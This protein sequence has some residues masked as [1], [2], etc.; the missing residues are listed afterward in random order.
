V[1]IETLKN[2][3]ELAVYALGILKLGEWLFSAFKSWWRVR[4]LPAKD[5]LEHRVR[6]RDEIDKNL[7]SARRYIDRPATENQL[8]TRIEVIDFEDVIVRDMK[9]IVRDM[10]RM[11]EFPNVKKTSVGVSPWLRLYPIRFYDRGIEV[12]LSD[13]RSVIKTNRGW[14]LLPRNQHSESAVYAATVG[15][16]P[17]HFIER[18]DWSRNDGYYNSPHFYCRYV[19]PLRG[20]Y[21]DIVY[22]VKLYP[23]VSEHLSEIGLRNESYEWGILKR[24]AFLFRQDVIGWWQRLKKLAQKI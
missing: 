23:E 24:G 12:F 16:I 9:R 22:K 1:I 19:G 6:M 2:I 15:R 5:I 20:P 21:E 7:K 8:A 11:D 4:R 14:C 18:I 13:S 3:S 17:F 10:K